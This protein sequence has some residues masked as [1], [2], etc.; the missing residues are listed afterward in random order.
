MSYRLRH[1]PRA[2]RLK[3]RVDRDGALV[4]TAPKGVRR[5]DI[6][7][8]VQGQDAWVARVRERL[9]RQREARDPKVCGMWPERIELPAV[10]EV[11]GVVY[12]NPDGNV[13]RGDGV[14]PGSLVHLPPNETREAVAGRLQ[15][16]LKQRARQT[17]TSR[18]DDLAEMHGMNYGRVS[19]RNQKSRWGSCSSNGNLSLNAR[20]LFCSPEA[21][22]YVLI[23]ELVHLEHPNHSPRFWQRV[24]EL[25]PDYRQR[26]RELKIVW[27][28][29]PDWVTAS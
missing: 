20:L 4:V 29:L 25:C 6:D 5:S 11:W 27:N 13:P 24:G 18:V 16:W 14:N 9:A 26:M 19:F 3:L 23:H 15:H 10:G 28:R 22:R 17:L 8:F 1:H 7:R 12:G 2:R 21:C